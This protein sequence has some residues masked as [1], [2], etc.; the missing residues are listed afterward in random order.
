MV[1]WVPAFEA[2]Y[3]KFDHRIGHY[4]RY[5]QRELLAL[6][7]KVGFQKVTARYVNMPGF[8][9]WWLIVRVLRRSPT[10][11]RLASIND[12]YVIPITRRVERFLRPP[13]GQSLLVVAQRS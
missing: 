3:S 10:D 5:R 6:V 13:V 2:L 7:H 12:R 9:A 11:S 1:L 4:R 8:F